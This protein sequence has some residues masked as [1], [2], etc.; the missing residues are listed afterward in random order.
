MQSLSWSQNANRVQLRIKTNSHTPQI[1]NRYG[2]RIVPNATPQIPNLYR[3]R[4]VP[5]ATRRPSSL[6]TNENQKPKLNFH[7]FY[8]PKHCGSALH[9]ST[10]TLSILQLITRQS[11][12]L[13]QHYYKRNYKSK[14][15]IMQSNSHSAC[16]HDGLILT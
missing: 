16:Y 5:N 13:R 10:L 7:A 12:H 8:I 11:T 6:Y 2:F 4:I 14:V 15:T 9:R 1:P 3:F